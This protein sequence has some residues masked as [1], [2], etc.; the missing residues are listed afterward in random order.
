MSMTADQLASC[1]L[2]S[3][4]LLNDTYNINF[5][6]NNYKM[7]SVS[8]ITNCLLISTENKAHIF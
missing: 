7:S 2:T 8:E 6:I 3:L 1:G 4:Q 5:I